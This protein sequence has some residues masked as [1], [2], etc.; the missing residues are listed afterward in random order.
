MSALPRY[1]GEM[2]YAGLR[3]TADEYFAL[4][5]TPERYELIDGVVMMSPSPSLPHQ[6]IVDEVQRQFG[7]WDRARARVYVFPDT[8]VRLRAD[9]VYRPDIAVYLRTRLHP[10]PERLTTA[11]DLIIEVLSFGSKPLDLITKRDDYE[12][13]GVSEYWVIDS[14]DASLRIWGRDGAILVPQPVMGDSARSSA[15]DGF[16]LD[17]ATLRTLAQ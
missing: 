15:I 11:P 3:M 4:G 17:L 8:D 13:F 2:G 14:M 10:V 9:R 5:E 1:P 12:R 7:A 16:E 6:L